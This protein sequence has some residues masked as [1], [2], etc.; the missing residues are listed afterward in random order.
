MRQLFF[1]KG[2]DEARVDTTLSAL[3]AG[4]KLEAIPEP[5]DE[6]PGG[7]VLRRRTP[8]KLAQQFGEGFA[9]ELLTAPLNRWIRLTS[10][11]GVHL[12]RIEDRTDGRRLTLE[13]AKGRLRQRALQRRLENATARALKRLRAGYTID[14]WPQ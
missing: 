11:L 8:Q 7:P 14:G 10:T 1:E 3:R 13:E 12:I 2:T 5:G 4:I 6:P 9:A